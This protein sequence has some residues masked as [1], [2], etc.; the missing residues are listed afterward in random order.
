MN[1]YS[2]KGEKNP[3]PLDHFDNDLIEEITKW[4]DTGDIIIMG[5]DINE[6]VRNGK[7]SVRLKNLGLKN[8]ILGNHPN[9]SPPATFH[10]NNTRTPIDTFYGSSTVEVSKAGYLPFDAE[11][12][13]SLSDGH[14]LGWIEVCNRSILGKEIPHSSSSIKSSGLQ[15]KDPR[16][17]KIYNRKV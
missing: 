13:A 15:S 3:N 1:F 12:P 5:I 9:S 17:R 2:N 4:M 11:S 10:Q 7:L 16:C 8:L 14:H 6:D